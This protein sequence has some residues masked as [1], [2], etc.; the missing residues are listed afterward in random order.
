[1]KSSK[2]GGLLI[3]RAYEEMGNGEDLEEKAIKIL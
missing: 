2:P 1:M 3:V